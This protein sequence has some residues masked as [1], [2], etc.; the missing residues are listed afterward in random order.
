[1][2]KL[3]FLSPIKVQNLLEDPSRLEDALA[4]LPYMQRLVQKHPDIVDGLKSGKADALFKAELASLRSGTSDL[5]NRVCH[6]ESA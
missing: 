3:D 5:E 2:S 1:M 6:P 4:D